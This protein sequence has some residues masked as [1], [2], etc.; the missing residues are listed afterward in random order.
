[1]SIYEIVHSLF[2]EY[3]LFQVKNGA[4]LI[5][6]QESDQLNKHIS[7]KSYYQCLADYL[8]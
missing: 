4:V 3:M 1:M 5:H 8:H 6:Y 2:R 7:M